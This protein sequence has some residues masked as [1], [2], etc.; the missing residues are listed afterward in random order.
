MDE[1]KDITV[2]LWSVV[3]QN[4]KRLGKFFSIVFRQAM[5]DD[6]L[7]AASGLVYSTLLAIVPALT[8][9]FTF[10]KA[11]GVLEPLTDFLSQW[12][13]EL[14]GSQAGGELML[15]LDRYT[16]NATSLG[17]VGLVSFLITMV[18]LIN[19]VWSAINRIYRSSRSRNPLK[20][21]A[22]YVTF[23]IIASLLLAAY[24]SVQSVMAS[25]YLDLLGVSIGRWSS[26]LRTLAP[27]LIVA[28]ILFLL[29]YFVPNTKVR[30][31]AAFLGSLA[32]VVFIG[33]FSKFTTI[34]TAMATNFSVIYGSFAAVFLFLFF[35]Y[36]FWATVFF[37]VELAYVHQFRPDAA[38]FIGLPQSP[39]LQLS[40]G[41]NIMML[42]GSNFR[43]GKGAT[44]V[45]EMLDRLAIPFNR[46][47]GFLALLAELNFITST[48]NSHTSFIP[49]QPLESLRLQ[50]LVTGLYGFETIDEV[51]HDTAGE[52]VALQV[53]DRGI[54]SLGAL[55]IENLLQRI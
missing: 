6:I 37:S 20:R 34:L 30:F 14:A 25:W 28:I 42:I 22:G 4:L 47:Q 40:E 38:S 18:L 8:F 11:L 53:Q 45:R 48:N 19:K 35:C 27:S 5:K 15:L 24:V 31:D 29:I 21:F 46:L 12:L 50:D 23:L 10:F 52:A 13:G 39:A 44:S 17:V 55:T 36:V 3:Q 49:K 41:T 7:N 43:D 26:V 54:A 1:K 32:G 51:E 9:M 16:R 33:I 2:T